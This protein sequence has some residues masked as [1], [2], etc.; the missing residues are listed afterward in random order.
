MKGGSEG[1]EGGDGGDNCTGAFTRTMGII[2]CHSLK[3]RRDRDPE[4][5]LTIS[6]FNEHWHWHRLAFR[7]P[8][9]IEEDP[10]LRVQEPVVVKPRGRP[11]GARNLPIS[12]TRRDLSHWE[13]ATQH[14]PGRPRGTRGSR[15]TGR[16]SSASQPSLQLG[17]R[18][19]LRT[20]TALLAGHQEKVVEVQQEQED[21]FGD[22]TFEGLDDDDFVDIDTI[23]TKQLARHTEIDIAAA[24]SI[25]LT[26]PPRSLP[27]RNHS[28][29]SQSLTIDPTPPPHTHKRQ[30]SRLLEHPPKRGAN[31]NRGQRARGRGRGR[32]REEDEFIDEQPEGT[33]GAFRLDYRR[34]G[35]HRAIEIRAQ[36]DWSRKLIES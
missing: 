8:P 19:A 11:Q 17:D 36:R 24:D 9:R 21:I 20:R 2:C 32:G 12:F 27:A 29:S 34:T 35:R 31:A 5:A 22:N 18:E 26:S 15:G 14:E 3:A 33:F 6:D 4:A 25:D 13:L 1:A 30:A 10:L 23:L 7:P 16:R 28:A